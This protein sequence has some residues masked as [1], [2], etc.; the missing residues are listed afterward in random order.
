[1]IWVFGAIRTV[2]ASMFAFYTWA[3]ICKIPDRSRGH[4]CRGAAP[5]FPIN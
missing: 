1:V 3:E 2:C 4:T 5:G